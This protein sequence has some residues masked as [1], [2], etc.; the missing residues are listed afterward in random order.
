MT[1]LLR[2]ADPGCDA[3]FL[4]ETLLACLGADFFLYLREVREMPLQRLKDGWEDLVRR[5]VPP[6]P[7]ES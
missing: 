4:A 5:T 1:L 6:A 2:E 3:E 7:A